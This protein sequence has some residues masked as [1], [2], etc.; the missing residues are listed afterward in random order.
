MPTDNYLKVRR[1]PR[2]SVEFFFDSRIPISVAGAHR[3]A[4]A[5]AK[6][7]T[8]TAQ[9]ESDAQAEKTKGTPQI[10]DATRVSV[11]THGVRGLGDLHCVGGCEL[12][13]PRADLEIVD[14]EAGAVADSET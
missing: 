14:N 3:A 11:W 1:P 10:V 2:P 5:Y 6:A 13:A 4:Q 7:L 9:T 12:C 8:E